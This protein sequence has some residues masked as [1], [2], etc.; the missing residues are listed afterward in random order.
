MVKYCMNCGS[1]LKEGIKF[2][3]IC[4]SAIEKQP[5]TQTQPQQQY[6]QQQTSAP[7]SPPWKPKKKLIIGILAIIIA[8]VIVLVVILILFSTGSFSGV[9]SRFVGEWEQDLGIGGKFLWKFNSDST[10]ATG[11]SGGAMYNIGT[12]KVN[13]DQLC[14][15][16][17]AV[18]YTYEFSNN[19]NTLTLNI[20]GNSSGYPLSFALTK[21]S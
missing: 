4:G 13:G 21:K 9:D 8:V 7:I 20:F 12:W 6:E 1:E 11:S 18:C 2:C 5:I 15:Y 19:G 16:N 17:N 3:S 14:L 10:L